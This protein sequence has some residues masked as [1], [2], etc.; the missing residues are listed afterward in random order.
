MWVL[1]EDFISRL[2]EVELWTQIRVLYYKLTKAA[3][4]GNPPTKMTQL[5]WGNKYPRIANTLANYSFPFFLA[6]EEKYAHLYIPSEFM[7]KE[8][9]VSQDFIDMYFPKEPDWIHEI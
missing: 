1:P 9:E 6:R 3:A 4:L 7:K 2:Y 5:E 8:I